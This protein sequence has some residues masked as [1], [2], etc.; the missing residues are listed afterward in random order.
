MCGCLLN[1][2]ERRSLAQTQKTK[3]INDQQYY[4]NPN[5]LKNYSPEEIDHCERSRY[6][7]RYVDAGLARAPNSGVAYKNRLQAFSQFVFKRMDG[8]EA[9][10][11]IVDLQ[12]GKK[13][14]VVMLMHDGDGK[15]EREEM[16]VFDMFNELLKFLRER[17]RNGENKAKL[18][19]NVI[20]AIVRTTKK[21]LK[22]SKVKV[23][24]EEFQDRV[25]L[26]RREKPAK[27]G[28]EKGDIVKLLNACKNIRLKTALHGLAAKG[29]RPI[30]LCAV[31][32]RDVD[33][34]SKIPTITFR[35]EYSKM[36]E[37]RTRPLTREEAA[38][39]RIW[40]KWKYRDRRTTFWS[41]KRGSFTG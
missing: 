41:E 7:K 13:I 22:F 21:F 8:K 37:A 9:D 32:N 30:E 27:A 35:A 10:E 36:R 23:D 1:L 2:H 31:R 40:L 19:A 34:D 5:R 17:G 25:Q 28:I 24:N 3:K 15:N 33:L 11:L 6:I 16:D 20:N 26:L 38:Q 12:N 39:Y 18:S 29:P 14:V 4:Y